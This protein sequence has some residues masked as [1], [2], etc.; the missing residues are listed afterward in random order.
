MN[1]IQLLVPED[2]ATMDAPVSPLRINPRSAPVGGPWS[3]FAPLHYEPGYSY[4]LLI[5]LHT[6]NAT[7]RQLTQIMPLVSLRNYVGVAPRGLP[8][9]APGPHRLT[10]G[11]DEASIEK[12]CQRV[13]DARDAAFRQYNIHSQR[14]FLAGGEAGGTMALRLA[15]EYPEAF[16]GVLSLGGPLPSGRAPL[17]GLLRARR[18]PVFLAQGR[19]ATSYSE[20][21]VC[22]DLRLL[23]SAG[24]NITLRQYPTGDEVNQLMF[25]DMNSWLME[26]VTGSTAIV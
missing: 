23:H 18:M 25:R 8:P 10:W 4:P 13:F 6:S 11:D 14:V 2:V 20:D 12:A 17:A 24:L 1:R 3:L 16:A 5:W 22:N 21:Q 9:V 19:Q 26:I 15:L 7:E